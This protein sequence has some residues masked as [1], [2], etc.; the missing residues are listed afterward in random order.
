VEGAAADRYA[1]LGEDGVNRIHAEGG[2]VESTPRWP[3][4]VNGQPRRRNDDG[5]PN[6]RLPFASA[7]CGYRAVG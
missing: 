5:L 2:L 4:P 3:A 7:G 1:F 6:S